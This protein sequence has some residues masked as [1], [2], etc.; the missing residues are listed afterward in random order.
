MCG[1]LT[2]L[3]S[4]R[5]NPLPLCGAYLI[6]GYCGSFLK[7]DHC[8]FGQIINIKSIYCVAR[9][10]SRLCASVFRAPYSA[11][12]RALDPHSSRPHSSHCST[13]HGVYVRG[14]VEF[15]ISPNQAVQTAEEHRARV[16]GRATARHLHGIKER[17][18]RLCAVIP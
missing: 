6:V 12:F 14:L 4:S 3:L 17:A 11:V 2:S 16:D 18:V 13:V 5:R 1:P 8:T 9:R 15:P 7:I 10:L